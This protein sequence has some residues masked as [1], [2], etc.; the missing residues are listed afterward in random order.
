MRWPAKASAEGTAVTSRDPGRRHTLAVM[1][2]AALTAAIPPARAGAPFPALERPAL[3]V[4]APERSVLLAVA[5]AGKRLVA[6]G[7]RG[8]VVLSDDDGR[9][10]RQ[11]VA[12]PSSVT[13]TAVRFADARHGWAIGHGGVILHSRDGGEIWHKQADGRSLAAAAV[14]AAGAGA[15]EQQ[16]AARQLADDGPDKPLLDLHFHDKHHGFVVGAYNLC[17]ETHDGGSTWTSVMPRLDNP[18]GLHLYAIHAD[19]G[20]LYIAGEQGL[21]LR[22]QDGGKTFVRLTSP[23]AGSWFSLAVPRPGVVVAAGL[24]GNI[25]VSA[26]RGE[27]WAAVPGAPPASIVGS[28]VSGD[29]TWVLVN[30][31]GQVLVRTGDGPL[32]VLAGAPLP[33]LSGVLPLHDGSMLAVGLAGVTLMPP[34]RGDRVSAGGGM[35]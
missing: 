25:F 22:S 30:Q 8:I 34:V 15:V 16:R 10:W 6:V 23:Y 24:R 21:L 29:G 4:R 7:E 35:R 27:S 14:D 33:P 5:H 28:A 32:R 19:G 11:A 13:L 12:V 18:K 17:F 3:A 2:G 9:R 26:D 1:L 20:T 31:P